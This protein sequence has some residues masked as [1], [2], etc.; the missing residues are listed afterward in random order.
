MNRRDTSKAETKKI[1]LNAARQLFWEK[2]VENCT[3]RSIAKEAS[4]APASVIVHF[5]NK[6]ALLEATLQD[7]IESVLT[8]TMEALPADQGIQCILLHLASGM[9][10]LYDK[11]RD[12]YRI[13]IRDTFFEQTQSSPS[14]AQLDEFYLNFFAR[15]IDQK[16]EL[17]EIKIEVESCLVATV[18]FSLYMGI[19]RDFLRS[20]DLSV[21]T[22]MERLSLMID[23]FLTGILV[24]GDSK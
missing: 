22:A 3:I 18:F 7:E 21:S 13:L 19:L 5:K 2:G 14:I 23:Y 17:G 11:N 4:V 12:L 1:I 24:V 6:T 15:L 16:K 9:F 8:S 20:S 10:S